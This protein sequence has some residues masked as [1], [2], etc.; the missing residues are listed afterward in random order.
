M[1]IKDRLEKLERLQQERLKSAP[2]RHTSLEELLDRTGIN[3]SEMREEAKV[4]LQESR[5]K[6]ESFI[7][8]MCEKVG[9]EPL[10]YK[11]WLQTRADGHAW[12]GDEWPQ[13]CVAI[14][15]LALKNERGLT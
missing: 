6:N 7:Q 10:V 13:A 2:E 1:S 8:T 9:I 11:R 15:C 12:K 4:F 3:A 14:Y 5:S